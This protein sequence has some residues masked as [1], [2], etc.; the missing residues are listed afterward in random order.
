MLRR[1]GLSAERWNM[2]HPNKKPRVPYVRECL[3]EAPG[4]CVAA[5]D[6]LK[7]LPDSLARW[8]PKGFYSLGTDGFGRSDSRMA[9]REFF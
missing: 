7:A 9:L 6:Y 3:A 4:V 2:L 5:S 8:F 1:D